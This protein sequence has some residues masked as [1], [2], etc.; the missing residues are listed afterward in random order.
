MSFTFLILIIVRKI[1]QNTNYFSGCSHP[2]YTLY[3]VFFSDQWRL[4]IPKMGAEFLLTKSSYNTKHLKPVFSQLTK[5]RG[6]NTKQRAFIESSIRCP[7]RQIITL[8]K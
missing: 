2:I 5:I 4:V 1:F 6:E 8:E 7:L 3:P